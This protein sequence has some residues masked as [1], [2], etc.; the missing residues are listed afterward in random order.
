MLPVK[1]LYVYIAVA[2]KHTLQIHLVHVLSVDN[3]LGFIVNKY[4]YYQQKTIC[5]ALLQF[6]GKSLI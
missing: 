6:C 3:L 1:C 2:Q 4:A 5:Y